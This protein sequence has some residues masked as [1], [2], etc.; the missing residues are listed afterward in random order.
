MYVFKAHEGNLVRFFKLQVSMANWKDDLCDFLE[1]PSQQK[2]MTSV[3]KIR[4]G[5]YRQLETSVKLKILNDLVDCCLHSSTIRNQID[6]NIEE[7]QLIVAQKREVE[8]EEV[9][10]K[11]EQKEVLKQQRTE[12]PNGVAT[13]N[14]DQGGES[15]EN[16]DRGQEGNLVI[17]VFRVFF[18]FLKSLII[19]S[20][21]SRS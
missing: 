20:F 15:L 12:H 10:R 8:V 4:Q 9:K 5:F 2:V 7:H 16:G 13:E 6:D 1:L 21:S 17:N 3:P 14:S 11:K 19:D 18:D